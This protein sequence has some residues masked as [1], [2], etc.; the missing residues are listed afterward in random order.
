MR[1]TLSTLLDEASSLELQVAAI[2]ERLAARF[3][4]QPTLAHFWTLFAEAERYHS[5]IIQMQKLGMSEPTGDGA[6]ISAW[7]EEIRETRAFLAGVI[8]RL[9]QGG[10]KPSV[11][12]AFDMAHDIESRSLEVQS[13]SFALFESPA[14]KDLVAR[15]HEEDMQ[16]RS[17]LLEAQQHFAPAS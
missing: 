15:M 2:Y 5:L 17:K 1:A 8:G 14:I 4:G 3:A 13:R 11:A 6:Q 7:G 9:D 12:E 16:H 10:W